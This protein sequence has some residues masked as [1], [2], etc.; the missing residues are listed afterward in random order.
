MKIKS[1]TEYDMVRYMTATYRIFV[2]LLPGGA[3]GDH[4][5]FQVSVCDRLGLDGPRW[6]IS[7]YRGEAAHLVE[8]INVS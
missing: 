3:V 8:R 1:M 2:R 4:G 7:V 6:A 5:E